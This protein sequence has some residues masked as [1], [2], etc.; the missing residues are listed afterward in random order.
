MPTDFTHM[1][2]N[3]GTFLDRLASGFGR[4]I[5][6][7]RENDAALF[8]EAILDSCLHHRA[9]DQQTES[10]RTEY[11]LDIIQATGEPEFYAAH[12]REALGTEDEDYSYGQLYELAAQFA[13]N[14]DAEARRV[15]YDR[16]GRGADR[17]DTTG[18]EDIVALDGLGGYLFVAD[19]WQRHPLPEK[20]QWEEAWLLGKLEEQ[21]GQEE[22]RQAL[23]HAAQDRPELAA[24]LAGVEQKR[25]QWQARRDSRE[26]APVPTYDDLR[27]RIADPTQTT[28]WQP[29]RSWTRRL[30]DDA[31]ARLAQDLL[32]ETDRGPLLKLLHLFR[33]R[34]FPLGIDRLLDLA[35]GRDEDIAEAARWVLGNLSDHRIRALAL[36]LWEAEESPIAVVHLLRKNFA[37]GDYARVE[38]LVSGD[39]PAD[40]FHHLAM[41]VRRFIEAHPTPEA[42]PT[43]LALYERGRCTLCRCSAVELHLPLGPLPPWILAEGRYDADSETRSLVAK[44]AAC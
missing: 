18:A 8:R 42:A 9:F 2:I 26:P 22:A 20:D 15:M 29:W 24:Y 28:R 25:T 41:I 32:A 5:L 11:L 39:M 13:R 23:R 40:D 4:V 38:R 6:F 37:G 43:L 3:A 34:A 12:I 16:F 14:G 21:A 17:R 7:L 10:Y 44:S 36:E 27:T 33:E 30:G 35:R 19:Q 31:L 1:P